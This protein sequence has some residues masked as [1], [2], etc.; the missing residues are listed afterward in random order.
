MAT[1]L[2]ERRAPEVAMGAARVPPAAGRLPAGDARGRGRARALWRST[3]RARRAPRR[4]SLLRR[5]RFA[6]RLAEA[7]DVYAVD[8]RR[9]GARRAAPAPPARRA[10]LRPVVCEATRDLFRA[11][12][13]GA[14]ELAPFDA[15]RLRSA[16][17]RRAG[18]IARTGGKRRSRR[19]SRF[20]ATRR[21]FARDVA[22]PHGGRLCLESRYAD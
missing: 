2:I 1:S 7:H 8:N 19:S 21:A 3:R 9:R 20:P 13:D 4:R 18:P 16:A 17:R 6:L 10:G 11:P 15:V 22:H 14:T 12:A 5:R